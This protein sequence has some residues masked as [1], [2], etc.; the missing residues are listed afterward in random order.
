MTPLLLMFSAGFART[1]GAARKEANGR[2]SKK[3]NPTI[4]NDMN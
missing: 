1:K 2:S 3:S 4:L